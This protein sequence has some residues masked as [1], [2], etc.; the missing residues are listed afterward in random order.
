MDLVWRC[1]LRVADCVRQSWRLAVGARIRANSGVYGSCRVG[2]RTR[3]ADAST[4]HREHA[5][6]ADGWSIRRVIGSMDLDRDPQHRSAASFCARDQNRQRRSLV[7]SG[8]FSRRRCVVRTAP[9][10]GGIPAES[11]RCPK[12]ERRSSKAVRLLAPDCSR[13]RSSCTVRCFARRRST[14]H[15]ELRA[16]TQ[17]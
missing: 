16:A 9:F 7:H 15:P 3:T 8:N 12:A 6:R 14:P 4:S 2:S 11:G 5:P 17:R 10:A 13:Y 1:K